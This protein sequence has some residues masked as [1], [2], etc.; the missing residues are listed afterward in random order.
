M[1][2]HLTPTVLNLFADGELAQD[3]LAGVNEHLAACK[4]C[5]AN[6]LSLMV[7]KSTT[8]RAGRR[9]AVPT[10]LQ[11]RIRRRAAHETPRAEVSSR[12]AV[13]DS[14]LEAV[15]TQG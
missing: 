12:N 13:T 8:A 15:A 3:Q 4:E 5:T 14:A 7:L 6:A 11:E 10:E 1:T 9:Y 2:E